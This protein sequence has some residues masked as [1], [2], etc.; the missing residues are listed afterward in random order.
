M[1][2]L[3]DDARRL[4]VEAAI[5][6]GNHGLVSQVQAILPALPLLIPESNARAICEAVLLFS[7]HRHDEARTLLQ[8]IALPEAAVLESCLFPS[9]R[10]E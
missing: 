9:D 1:K 5:A 7:L 4:V 3:T 8:G 10:E 6:G 2:M